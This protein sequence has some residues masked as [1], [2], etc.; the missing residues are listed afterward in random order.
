MI[1]LSESSRIIAVISLGKASV[2]I[3][4]G[5]P[6]IAFHTLMLFCPAIK[7]CSWDAEYLAQKIGLS[8]ESSGIKDFS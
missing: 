5:R 4:I 1:F 2:M 6:E 8:S 3:L 7:I